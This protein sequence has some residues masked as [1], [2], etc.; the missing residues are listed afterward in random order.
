MKKYIFFFLIVLL[1]TSC[2]IKAPGAKPVRSGRAMP[3]ISDNRRA[4][5]VDDTKETNKEEKQE[6]K[7]ENKNEPITSNTIDDFEDDNLRF[8]DTTI[9]ASNYETAQTNFDIVMQLNSAIEKFDNELYS[10]ACPEFSA[11]AGTFFETDSLYFEAKFYICECMLINDKLDEAETKLIELAS[12]ADCPTSIIEKVLLRIGHIYC[13]K[14]NA[15]QAN[16]YFDQLKRLNKNSIM[17]PYAECDGS[18]Y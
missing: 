13:A 18:N 11:L 15:K 5:T 6:T 9:I 7:K 14:G 17:I 12:N 4:R 1:I 3:R 2:S 8:S 10:L 16:Y